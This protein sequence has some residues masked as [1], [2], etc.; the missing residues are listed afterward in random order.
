MVSLSEDYN[1]RWFREDDEDA[2][3]A[4]LNRNL[5]NEYDKA[6][7]DWKWRKNPVNIGFIPIAVVEHNKNDL[8]AFNSFLPIEIRR[9]KQ[10][11][12]AIQGCDGFVEP[13]H[14][15]RGLFQRTLVFLEEEALR[16][17]AEFL[18]GFNLIEA[19]G[20]AHKAGSKIAYDMNKCFI[21]P[22]N[23]R[24]SHSKDVNLKLINV[25]TLHRLYLEWA[26]NSRLF[27]IN[28]TLEYL[29]W[30]IKQHPFKKLQ[31]Y[32]VS[33]NHN[34]IG[35]VVTDKVTESE[36]TTLTINDYNPGLIS[37]HLGSIVEKLNELNDDLTVIEVDTI[38]GGER[39]KTARKLGFKITPWYR[40]IMKALKG[41]EQRE[42][43]VYWRS[44]KLSYIRNW[45]LAE[46]DI[47]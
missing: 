2:Y 30:K 24:V 11:F 16:L 32:T 39:Q 9:G 8:V 1:V 20:A 42:G 25:E 14:R 35:Y 44:L 4:G 36:K 10:I 17:D 31:P 34:I 46:S 3:I 41:T 47:F 38:Q 21:K 23:V 40:V 6:I 19:A 5:Y 37:K 43:N 22:E 7:F 12:R 27:N 28:R 15:R 45:H 26:E 29:R 13:K 33:Q 18:M